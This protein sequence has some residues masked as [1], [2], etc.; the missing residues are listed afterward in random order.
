MAKDTG[1]KGGKL[2]VFIVVVLV[3][4]V[5][6][7]LIGVGLSF[8]GRISPD[9]VIPDAFDLYASVPNP[10]ELAE[11]ILGHESLADIMAIPELASIG[12]ALARLES[13]R[14]LQNRFVRFAAKGRLDAGFLPEGRILAAWDAGVLSPL[15]RFLPFLAGRFTI[16][17]LYY[18]QAGKNSR[19]EYRL[20]NGTVF[21]IG[22]HKNLLVF[23]NSSALFESVLQ[24]T[25]RD[26]DLR[27][28][29]VKE[30][31]SRDYDIAF[32]L[33]PPALSGLIG[34]ADPKIAAALSL[35]QFP[36]TVEAS[37]RVLPK[38]LDLQ[39]ISPLGSGS[40]A[41]KSIVERDSGAVGLMGIIPET[42]QYLT[43]LAA[44]PLR[45]IL[46][47]AAAVSGPDFDRNYTKADSMSRTILGLSMDEILCSWTGAE[48]ALFGLEGQ[49]QVFLG[50][51]VGQ[52]RGHL[53]VDFPFGQIDDG[54]VVLT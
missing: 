17:G 39:L 13:S 53:R 23:S 49:G 19:F 10:V 25:S 20:D 4:I 45:E 37:L 11:R 35:L 1:K 28:S 3:I 26:G 41:L 52:G 51:L 38:Q 7:P 48:F 40:P 33:S 21:F 14:A 2:R 34:T 43:L 46:N 12:P 42:A 31:Y 5:G 47:A 16:P 44:G 22:R 24:G 15:L 29:S 32:L 27:K 18:V 54:V 50:H 8:I 6:L 30:F 9:S 36:G